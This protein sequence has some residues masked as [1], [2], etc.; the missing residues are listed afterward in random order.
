M[1]QS[2]ASATEANIGRNS[3][4]R[5]SQHSA[6]LSACTL[7][8]TRRYRTT[9][10]AAVE[11]FPLR[12]ARLQ[13]PRVVNEMRHAPGTCETWSRSQRG[14][15]PPTQVDNGAPEHSRCRRCCQGSAR[16]CIRGPEAST[17]AHIEWRYFACAPQLANL[18][19]LSVR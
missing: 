10:W 15:D 18:R 7:G 12:E 3:S 1:R 9:I 5:V 14:S 17:K 13:L 4:R 16:E 6:R 2:E 19:Q 8:R 11:G